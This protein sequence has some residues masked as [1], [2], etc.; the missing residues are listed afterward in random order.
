M[1]VTK[2]AASSEDRPIIEALIDQAREKLPKYRK[3]IDVV[4]PYVIMAANAVDQV[5]PYVVSFYVMCLGLYEKARP[6][7]PE[8]FA[9]LAF[10]LLL[11][12]FGGSYLTL[13]A[14]IEAVR[15]TVWESI[16]A[17]LLVLHRNYKKAE[18]ASKKDDEIDAN[19]D[20]VADVKQITKQELLSRKVY[21]FLR[22][23]DPDEVSTAIMALWGGF[24]SIVAT[25]RVHFA[26]AVTLGCSFGDMFHRHFQKHLEPAVNDVLPPELKKW[27]PKAVMYI[28][29]VGGVIIA[30]FLRRV[31]TGFHSAMRGGN[32]AVTHGIALGKK[33]NRIPADFD[34]NSPRASAI[35][36]LVG[37]V[38]FYWQLSNGFALPFPLNVLFLPVTI[39]EWVLEVAVGVSA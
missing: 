3:Q 38:G 22:T 17:S 1:S 13:I 34:E 14:A 20:G 27:T 2:K 21:L 29:K 30:W 18:S 31:I 8:Q 11:C 6:Y 28:C 26:Q 39:V 10:G 24:L 5:W 4:A 36:A 33:F 12:F 19:N 9:P 16:K 32:M 37:F 15:L 25:L 7:N 35:A 23:V